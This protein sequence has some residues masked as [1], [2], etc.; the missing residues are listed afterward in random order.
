[1]RLRV[2]V[3]NRETGATR[4]LRVMEYEPTGFVNLFGS[5]ALLPCHCPTCQPAR[6]IDARAERRALE[7]RAS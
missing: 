1:M 7:A 6:P 5:E 3:I 2:Y 4:E